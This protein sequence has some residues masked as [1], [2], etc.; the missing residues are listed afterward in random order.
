MQKKK[1]TQK[2][3][4]HTHK[5]KQKKTSTKLALPDVAAFVFDLPRNFVS[6]AS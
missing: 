4:T 5:K 2:K 1:I 6:L 3:H